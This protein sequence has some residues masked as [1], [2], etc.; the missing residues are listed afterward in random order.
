MALTTVE[1]AL[2]NTITA[3]LGPLQEV[4]VYN[5]IGVPVA[6]TTT[7]KHTKISFTYA[8]WNTASRRYFWLNKASDNQRVLKESTDIS[9]DATAG[10][11]TLLTTAGSVFDSGDEELSPG[12]EIEGSYEFKYFTDD[13]FIQFLNLGLIWF[14]NRAPA[15]FISELDNITAEFEYPI[16]MY[17]YH[18]CLVRILMDSQFWNYKLI[19]ASNVGYKDAMHAQVSQIAQSVWQ[20]V[21]T[22]NKPRRLSG[23]PVA[24]VSGKFATQQRVTGSNFARYTIL[25][26]VL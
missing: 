3:L 26:N 15:T 10:E 21:N 13:E 25:G 17:A 19:W 11:I 7:G 18:R 23:P 20:E 2:V 16:V 5:E 9:V 4:A 12:Q 1:T 6:D 22:S 8:N 24:V 14:N